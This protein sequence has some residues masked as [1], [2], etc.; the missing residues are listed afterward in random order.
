MPKTDPRLS[1]RVHR[2]V[3]APDPLTS[4]CL[5]PWSCTLSPLPRLSIWRETL[6]LQV[7]LSALDFLQWG[8]SETGLTTA[9]PSF[10]EA[11]SVVRMLKHYNQAKIYKKS[12]VKHFQKIIKFFNSGLMFLFLT[13]H[14]LNAC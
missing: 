1:L 11:A 4:S 8:Q 9:F 5:H 2:E 3:A 13:S 10:P 7:C 14:G 12:P 6:P